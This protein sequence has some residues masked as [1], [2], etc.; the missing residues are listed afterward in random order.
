MVRITVQKLPVFHQNDQMSAIE[1]P[2]LPASHSDDDDE[3]DEQD[4]NWDDWQSDGGAASGNDDDERTKSLFCS[5]VLASPEAAM[6]HDAETFGFDL[7]QFA[8]RERL[9]EYDI[10]RCINWIRRQVAAGR[11]PLPELLRAEG[12]AAGEWRGNDDFLTPAMADDAL[13]FYDYEEV[14]EACR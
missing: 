8:A 1:D 14:V 4:E 3:A 7:R 12:A 11:D 6:Q 13:L 10:F 5:K 9:D 2:S